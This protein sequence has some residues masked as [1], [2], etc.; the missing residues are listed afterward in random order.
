MVS[1]SAYKDTLELYDELIAGGCTE[2]QARVQARQLG[3]VGTILDSMN[4]KLD[5]IDKDL[6]WMRVIGGVMSA[7]FFANCL[8]PWIK[9]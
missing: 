8:I 1:M 9:H 3:S 6:I 7:T 5:K 4:S 2:K